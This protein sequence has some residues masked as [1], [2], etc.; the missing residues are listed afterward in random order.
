MRRALRA[1]SVTST[2]RRT[3]RS[4]LFV[5]TALAAAACGG[6]T[7]GDDGG[8][9]GSGGSSGSGATGGSGGSGGDVLLPPECVVK[10][11]QP[12]PHAVTFRFTNT[13]S[14]RVFVLQECTLRY[15]IQSCADGYSDDLTLNAF[16]TLGCDDPNVGCIA[17]GA[18]AYFGEPI[19]SGQS[20]EHIW[21]G[22]TYTFG[23]TPD[24]CQCS[25]S[26]D[27]PAGK[28]RVTIPVYASDGDA[29]SGTVLRTV[30]ADFDLPAEGGVVTVDLG[31]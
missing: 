16:C 15:S 17:C 7:A 10:T 20:L 11:A 31:A 21:Q 24:G 5:L 30:T 28:Y 27:A 29:Q 18:C 2:R 4:I 13:G 6:S 22:L 14:D 25:N 19:D 9:G 3:K 26:H 23:Q 12:S 1:T 8:G